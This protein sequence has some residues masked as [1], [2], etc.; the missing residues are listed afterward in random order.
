[1][2]VILEW[3]LSQ[4][5]C[6]VIVHEVMLACCAYDWGMCGYTQ[7]HNLRVGGPHDA[8]GRGAAGG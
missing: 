3:A 6:P 7:E 5:A 4:S 8:A 1:M 2:W